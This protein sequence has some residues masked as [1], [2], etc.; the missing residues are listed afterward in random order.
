MLTDLP[1]EILVRLM[2]HMEVTDSPS[3]ALNCK[4][5]AR[6]ATVHRAL[7]VTLAAASNAQK[8]EHFLNTLAKD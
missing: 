1:N 8:I 6:V 3:L 2:C 5:L 7:V 4:H